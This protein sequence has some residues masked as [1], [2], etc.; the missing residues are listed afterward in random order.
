MEVVFSFKKEPLLGPAWKVT[1]YAII[2]K[3][4][5]KEYFVP[6]DEIIRAEMFGAANGVFRFETT[7]KKHTICF[8]IQNWD[9]AEEAY[10][11]VMAHCPKAMEQMLKDAADDE[12]RKKQL[13]E[14][15]A[16]ALRNYSPKTSNGKDAS[17][18]GRAIV[19]GVVAGPVGAVVGALS[20]VDKNNRSKK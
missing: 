3:K 20:A 15:F 11:Y 10:Q 9:R 18:V 16:H 4:W 1:D 12:A 17:V 6:F 13:A 5:G 2:Y 19:G 8:A 7:S 14:D